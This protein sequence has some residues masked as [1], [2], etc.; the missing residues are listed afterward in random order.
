[1]MH[2]THASGKYGVGAHIPTEVR[3][4]VLGVL[5]FLYPAVMLVLFAANS[6]TRYWHGSWP[7]FAILGILIWIVVNLVLVVMRFITPNL[8]VVT[9]IIFPALTMIIICQVH[10]MQLQE[11]AP[12]LAAEDCASF[13]AKAHLDVAWRAASDVMDAC[14]QDLSALTGA[15]LEEKRAVTSFQSCPGYWQQLDTWGHEWQYLEMLERDSN[16][17]GWCSPQRPLWGKSSTVQDQCSDVVALEMKGSLSVLTMQLLVYSV[18]VFSSVLLI[19]LCVPKLLLL[20]G[21]S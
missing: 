17:G 16:C 13:L 18:A 14:V 6:T 15:P 2:P 1:M 5:L 19:L 8:G 7:G 20:P 11:T 3:L 9:M 4:V 12:I 10:W 21:S